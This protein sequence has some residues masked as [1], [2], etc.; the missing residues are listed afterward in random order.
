MN[1]E[2]IEVMHGASTDERLRKV[3]IG[4]QAVVM[5][6]TGDNALMNMLGGAYIR[7]KSWVSYLY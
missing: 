3:R 6:F 4:G 7:L 5:V 1:A 2:T